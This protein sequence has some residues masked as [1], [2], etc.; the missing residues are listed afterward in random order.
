MI[1]K[2]P[3]NS[4]V[5]ATAVIGD[6]ILFELISG[7][8]FQLSNVKVSLSVREN[9]TAS[10]SIIGTNL[11]GISGDVITLGDRFRLEG[12]STSDGISFGGDECKERRTPDL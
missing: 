2:K 11:M 7:D 5:T 10:I 6:D 8:S 12:T 1:Q 9:N 4:Q 3:L